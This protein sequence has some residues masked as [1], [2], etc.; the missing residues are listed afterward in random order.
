MATWLWQ[1]LISAA[2]V[3]IVA[4]YIINKIAPNIIT[5]TLQR[6]WS[7]QLEQF[8]SDLQTVLERYKISLG[9]LHAVRASVIAELY[10]KLLRAW[11][12]WGASI[13]RADPSGKIDGRMVLAALEA[14]DDFRE[15]SYRSRLYLTSAANELIYN[16]QVSLES[17]RGFVQADGELRGGSSVADIFTEYEEVDQ[18]LSSLKDAMEREFRKILGAEDTM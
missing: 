3:L 5:A 13:V 6:Q 10:A 4:L 11:W 14:T 17:L 8:K 12:A 7:Q 15:V 2:S 1:S 18:F 16:A 9:T